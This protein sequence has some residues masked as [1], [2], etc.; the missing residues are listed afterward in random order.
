MAHDRQ[1]DRFD[2]LA[3][4]DLVASFRSLERRLGSVKSRAA[5]ARLS[6]VIDRPGPSGLSLDALL[7]E[8]ARGGSLVVNALGTA[9]DAVEPIVPA[10][11]LDPSERVF[12]DDR[13]WSVEAS[14]D[15][16]TADAARAADRVD[17]ASA[18]ELSRDVAVTGAGGTTPLAIAQQLCRELIDAL[19]AGERHV[20]WLESQV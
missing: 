10:P 1:R 6:D 4:R 2:K 19:T 9:L 18:A 5:N 16:I 14:V 8:A 15:A 12:T 20:E 11:T 7:A 17:E 13:G 3:P